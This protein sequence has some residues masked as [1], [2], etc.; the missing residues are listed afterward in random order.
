MTTYRL[1]T[2]SSVIR[3]PVAAGYMDA[4]VALGRWQSMTTYRFPHRQL[5]HT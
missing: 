1:L 5:R 3:E 4:E 2:G